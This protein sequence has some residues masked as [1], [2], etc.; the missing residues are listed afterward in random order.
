[1]ITVNYPKHILGVLA[2]VA[3]VVFQVVL[4]AH[5]ATTIVS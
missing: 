5:S 4:F 1:M 2:A 3:V